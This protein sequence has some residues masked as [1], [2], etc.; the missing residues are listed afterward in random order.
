MPKVMA[1][2]HGKDQSHITDSVDGKDLDGISGGKKIF[3]VKRHQQEGRQSQNLPSYE[4]RFKISRQD[5]NVETYIE[6]ENGIEEALVT[7]FTVQVVSAVKGDQESQ[8]RTY[9]DIHRPY[10]IKEEVNQELEMIAFEK[11]KFFEIESLKANACP[12]NQEH[13]N[14]GQIDPRGVES[15]SG[16]QLFL[17]L[18]NH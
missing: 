10:P 9:H 12:E 13:Q 8:N 1:R 11:N 3:P 16:K 4:E 6:E 17:S 7:A 15:Y 14:T 5:S 2:P 18:G